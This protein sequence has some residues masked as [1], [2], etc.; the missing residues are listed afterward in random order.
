MFYKKGILRYFINKLPF[1]DVTIITAVK[2]YQKNVFRGLVGKEL[3]ISK[4]RSLSLI[5]S[6]K[7]RHFSS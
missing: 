6:P 7:L 5:W 3:L 2:I 4:N 1:L